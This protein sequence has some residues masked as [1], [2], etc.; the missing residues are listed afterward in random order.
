[1]RRKLTALLVLSLVL[2]S[3]VIATACTKDTTP[4]YAFVFTGSAEIGDVTYDIELTADKDNTFKLVASGFED[5]PLEGTYEFVE[6]KGYIFRF[7]DAGDTEIKT[8]YSETLKEFYFYYDLDLGSATGAGKARMSLPDAAFVCDGE[9]WGWPFSF[10]Y[11]NENVLL[12][13][14]TVETSI[15]CKAD[16]TAIAS[17]SCA[18][19][20]VPSR[21]GTWTYDAAANQYAFEL[22]GHTVT[23]YTTTYDAERDTYSVNVHFSV[24]MMI[25][26]IVEYTPVLPE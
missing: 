24:G 3:A 2:L 5:L 26:L 13:G 12:A 23:S 8:H 4:A 17:A 6:A 1:M 19:I 20:A 18:I 25:S 15:L 9:D 7:N 14:N 11:T 10:G 21:E 22:G 16:G